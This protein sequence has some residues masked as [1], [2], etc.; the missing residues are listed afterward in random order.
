MTSEIYADLV[1]ASRELLADPDFIRLRD[2]IA[3]ALAV[4]PRLERDDVEALCQAT[5][6]P[7]PQAK[8]LGA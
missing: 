3:R 6:T 5:G 4:V 8:E 2:A 7:V 1:Q